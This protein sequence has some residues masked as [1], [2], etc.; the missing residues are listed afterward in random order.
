MQTAACHKLGPQPGWPC[1]LAPR[2]FMRWP[3]PF[4]HCSCSWPFQA[5]TS[6]CQ[7]DHGQSV[8]LFLDRRRDWDFGVTGIDVM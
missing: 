6:P 3:V 5:S 8:D 7:N 1:S 2:H 4:R